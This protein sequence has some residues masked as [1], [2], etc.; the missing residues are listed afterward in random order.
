MGFALE[1]NDGD[2]HAKEKLHKKN[3]DA[4]VLNVLGENG[5]GF[6]FETNKIRIFGIKGQ[7]VD[8]PLESKTEL[9][10]KLVGY[11]IENR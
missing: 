5:V 8:F 4:V 11:I 1:T 6:N 3:L 10:K 9:A 7:R 2:T